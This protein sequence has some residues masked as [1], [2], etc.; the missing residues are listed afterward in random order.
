MNCVGCSYTR[1]CQLRMTNFVT[2]Q[3]AIVNECTLRKFLQ[4]IDS[5]CVCVHMQSCTCTNVVHTENN[6]VYTSC[7]NFCGVSQRH[8]MR[9]I[10]SEWVLF[11]FVRH[12]IHFTWLNKTHFAELDCRNRVVS[13]CAR[14][15]QCSVSM[16][17][18][19]HLK[20]VCLWSKTYP[21]CLCIPSMFWMHFCWPSFMWIHI[22][23]DKNFTWIIFVLI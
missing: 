8:T 12:A 13:A 3:F 20:V 15:V 10:W 18:C 5:T 19:A 17:K 2:F 6:N 21:V 14:F 9:Y 4:T 16:R 22:K 11:M 1:A 23:I 7:L